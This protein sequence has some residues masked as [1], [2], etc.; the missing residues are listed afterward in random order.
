[1][2][3]YIKYL[4]QEELKVKA[5]I[6]CH[7]ILATDVAEKIYE[8]QN[9]SEM[10]KQGRYFGIM[11]KLDG[12]KSSYEIKHIIIDEAQDYNVLQYIL[13]KKIL[14]KSKF[15]I[16]GDINQTINPYYKYTSLEEL[17]KIFDSSKP[18]SFA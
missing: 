2:K 1:M 13:L 6:I 3:V 9:P 4:I 11:I 15:T 10:H 12:K 5:E 14:K 16:L 7:G 17:T 8:H 18:Y